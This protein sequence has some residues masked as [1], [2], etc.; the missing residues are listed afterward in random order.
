M[1]LFKISE[2]LVTETVDEETIK[3]IYKKWENFTEHQLAILRRLLVSK[4]VTTTG[5]DNIKNNLMVKIKEIHPKGV[6][7]ELP[8]TGER[9]V[10][11]GEFL[12]SIDL[13]KVLNQ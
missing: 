6:V 11:L 7:L 12:H 4:I 9:A 2:K 13:Y 1:N 10:N 3:S 5:I 8:Y